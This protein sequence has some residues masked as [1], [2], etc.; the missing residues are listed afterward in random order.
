M[1]VQFGSFRPIPIVKDVVDAQAET[2]LV[3]AGG[4]GTRH[5][6]ISAT[7]SVTVAEAGKIVVVQEASGDDW[8][9]VPMDTVGVHHIPFRHGLRMAAENVAINWSST[10]TGTGKAR[11]LVVYATQQ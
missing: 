9:T 2:A 10:S 4:A 6:I 8:I 5:I 11:L 3:A 7:V 1:D